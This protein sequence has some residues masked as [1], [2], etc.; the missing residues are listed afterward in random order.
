MWRAYWKRILR[1]R[2][3]G[4]RIVRLPIKDREELLAH[5]INRALGTLSFETRLQ[6]SP[7][8]LVLLD[9]GQPGA[10]AVLR[11]HAFPSLPEQRLMFSCSREDRGVLEH[12]LSAR[13][14]KPRARW[15]LP[16]SYFVRVVIDG[17][18]SLVGRAVDLSPVDARIELATTLK[19]GTAVR[20][21]PVDPSGTLLPPRLPA[22][23]MRRRDTAV[24]LR[25]VEDASG[26][27]RLLRSRMRRA[28]ESGRITLIG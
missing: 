25:F 20:I 23:V 21:Q 19:P 18:E 2:A 17:G 15:R 24:V 7:G 9:L 26:S 28:L 14:R 12:L 4:H 11:A 5:V 16:V 27:W 8:E 6:L 13:Q 10:G 1:R 22:Y 3:P